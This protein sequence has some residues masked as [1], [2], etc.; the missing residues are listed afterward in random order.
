MDYLP[1]KWEK[2][3]KEE[4]TAYNQCLTQLLDMEPG[5]LAPCVIAHCQEDSCIASIQNE[6]DNLVNIITRA[7]KILPRHHPGVQKHWWTNELTNLKER[8]IEIHRLW[9]AGQA[10][11]TES[12]F[13]FVQPTDEPSV[14]HKKHL[15]KLLGIG[16]MAPGRQR[17]HL[18]SGNRG[19]RCTIRVN[20]ICILLST[21]SHHESR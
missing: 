7:D 4:K 9:Q 12:G 18:N 10:L 21:E 20:L 14:P 8:S 5:A 2:C 15:S 16:Y 13:E 1:K 11:Q 19:I 6:Y 17:T 3:S